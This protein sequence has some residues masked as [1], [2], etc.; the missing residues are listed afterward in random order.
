MDVIRL[1]SDLKGKPIVAITNGAIIAKVSD[2]LVDPV[3]RTVSAIIGAAGGLLRRQTLVIPVAAIHVWGQD[4]ILFLGQRV[5][6]MP[7]KKLVVVSSSG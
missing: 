6:I 1:M 7:S 4:V 2:L 5:Y 3:E